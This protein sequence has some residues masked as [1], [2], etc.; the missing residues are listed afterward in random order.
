MTICS[1]PG[2]PEFAVDRGR[3]ETHRLTDAQR[4]YGRAH[5]Q[6]R[7]ANRAGAKCEACGCTR[8][9]QRDH[10][11]P[12]SMGGGEDPANKRWLCACPEHGCHDRLGVKTHAGGRFV[13]AG[14]GR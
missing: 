2:C 4:G 9:L 11:V 5:R 14:A 1:L 8:N 13:R 12:R 3:C 7:A 6:D 10:R